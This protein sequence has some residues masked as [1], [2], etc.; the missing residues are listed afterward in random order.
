MKKNPKKLR[1]NRETAR[2]RMAHAEHAAHT[3]VDRLV[4]GV[5]AG[6][7]VAALSRRM[8]SESSVLRAFLATKDLRHST[9]TQTV[10][11]VV[12]RNGGAP[13]LG[14]R[15]CDEG[16]LPGHVTV[17]ALGRHDQALEDALR[18]VPGAM[19]YERSGGRSE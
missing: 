10:L 7:D 2:A 18:G 1:L 19:I 13:D 11:A 8:A 3:L 12:T 17:V 4:P 9:G 16:L 14:R 5:V 15:L 6:I